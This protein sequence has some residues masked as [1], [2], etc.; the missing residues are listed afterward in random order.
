[1][2]TEVARL[3]SRLE[4]TTVYVTHDQTEAMT[5]GDRVAVMRGGVLQQVGTPLELYN[6]PKNLFVA[7]F[8]GSPAMNFLSARVEG[9]TL[10]LPMV[11]VP[12][13]GEMKQACTR[14][15]GTLIAG[16]RPEHFEDAAL[17]GD[18]RD[19][20]VT[21][22]TTIDVVESMGSELYVYF[23]VQEDE[24]VESDAL[25][26]LAR[27]AGTEGVDAAGG[28]TNVVA[29]LS[30]ESGVKQRQEAELW[31]DP[32]KIQIFDAEGGACLTA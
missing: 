7:G 8:I 21:F 30:P 15:E 10:H 32:S 3:Q 18:E 4:T 6:H 17:I 25:E 13:E 19:R 14:G 23:S 27:D 22:N 11:D 28:G 9:D 12:L 31:L 26:E 1:M 20:G 2:R 5:L 16:I 29:R 24:Q